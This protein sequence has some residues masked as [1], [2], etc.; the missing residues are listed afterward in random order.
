[1]ERLDLD[2]NISMALMT[3]LQGAPLKKLSV[4]NNVLSSDSIHALACVVFL[5]QYALSSLL[6]DRCPRLVLQQPNWWPCRILS[7]GSRAIQQLF[8]ASVGLHFNEAYQVATEMLAMCGSLKHDLSENKIDKR[9]MAA[10]A[11]G[12][13]QNSSLGI[14]LLEGVE[15]FGATDVTAFANCAYCCVDSI[16]IKLGWIK[17]NDQACRELGK[18]FIKDL[19]AWLRIDVL[20]HVH[21]VAD[22][23]RVLKQRGR[24]EE[25]TVPALGCSQKLEESANF[26]PR[27]EAAVE[28][29]IDILTPTDN[30]RF[31][32]VI[33][34]GCVGNAEMLSN[35]L[36]RTRTL[37]K[38]KF[39]HGSLHGWEIPV[40]MEALSTTRASLN[41]TLPMLEWK[42]RPSWPLPCFRIVHYSHLCA[43]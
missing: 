21:N 24:L 18:I 16:R 20:W 40:F 35:Y 38:L 32:R 10:P 30:V 5:P 33:N 37:C 29:L 15:G 11:A 41:L 28:H 19:S 39:M 4:R 23:A 42:V 31:Q 27:L 7:C 17:V 26:L 13:A 14:M 8:L 6:E 22:F 3:K 1:T 12:V 36:V 34:A 2:E 25:F 43:I 9:S